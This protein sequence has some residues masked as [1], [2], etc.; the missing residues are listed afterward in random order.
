M[1]LAYI[2]LNEIPNGVKLMDKFG[3]KILQTSSFSIKCLVIDLK[4]YLLG[5]L[6]KSPLIWLIS[7]LKYR[8][9]RLFYDN[10]SFNIIIGCYKNNRIKL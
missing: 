6:Y 2:K 5:N 7:F 1:S 3:G 9:S 8:I 4:N 10:L